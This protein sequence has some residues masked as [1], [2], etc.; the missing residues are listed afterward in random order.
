MPQVFKRPRSKNYYARFQLGGRDYCITTGK[1]KKSEALAELTRLVDVANGS[2][3][4]EKCCD[5]LVNLIERLPLTEQDVKRRAMARRILQGSATKVSLAKTWETWI[6]NPKKGNPGAGTLDRYDCYWNRFKDWAEKQGLAYLHEVA[7]AHVEDYAA[8][9]WHSRVTAGTYNAHTSFLRSMFGVLRTKSGLVTNPW[10]EIPRMDVAREGRRQLTPDELAK[11]CGSAQGSLR[12]MFGIGL[13]TG[14]RLNDVVHLR[15]D[16][17]DFKHGVIEHMPSKTRRKN[18]KLRLPVHPVL[19]VLLKELRQ[20]AKGPLL[21]PVEAEL[22][23]RD[24]GA[25]SKRIQ[26]FL[27]GCGITTVE[28]AEGGHRQR[29]IVRVGFH[30]LRHSFVS[31]CAANRVPQVAIM[32]LVGHGS[33]AMTA[34]YSHAGE[35]QKAKAIA[36]LPALVFSGGEQ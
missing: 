24:G 10:H 2:A 33:P 17:I 27:K 31:L 4:L 20:T 1:S 35:E 8:D 26:S 18:K 34:L 3:S 29:A 15:W 6:A 5:S 7:P 19:E 21:F 13:Y 36:A 32:E 11:V 25:L 30:S 23:D 22:Y 16:E 14:M 9:L 12:Y 28:K